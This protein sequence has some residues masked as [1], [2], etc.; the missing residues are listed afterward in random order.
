[1]WVRC[2]AGPYAPKPWPQD[3]FHVFIRPLRRAIEEGNPAV[4]RIHYVLL[5]AGKQFPLLALV[6]IVEGP[7][8]LWNLG[9]ERFLERRLI[10]FPA[11]GDGITH[12]PTKLRRP[13]S[14]TD[15]ITFE[16]KQGGR[17][18]GHLKPFRGEFE[19]RPYSASP[20]YLPDGD[21]LHLCSLRIRSPRDMDAAGIAWSRLAIP[22][23]LPE[24]KIRKSID[25]AIEH[26][27]H[28]VISI[29]PG[30]DW[31]VKHHL[32]VNVLLSQTPLADKEYPLD[33]G[34]LSARFA[35]RLSKVRLEADYYTRYVAVNL[36]GDRRLIVALAVLS[37]VPP[38]AFT[39]AMTNRG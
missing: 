9:P 4:G 7:A 29:P 13:N 39:L 14:K 22:S 17:V 24:T 33:P 36:P 26:D 34:N 30:P 23:N 5:D 35:A 2:P 12:T 38:N 18:S 21:S 37:G 32:S 20:V 31:D 1:M 25:D 6:A 8:K 28:P 16:E 15:H 19:Q 10:L 27:G 3:P 11:W